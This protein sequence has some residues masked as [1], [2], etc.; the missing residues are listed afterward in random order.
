MGGCAGGEVG[1][2]WYRVRD[3]KLS[4][5]TTMGQGEAPQVGEGQKLYLKRRI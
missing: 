1:R 2:G 4:I 3:N 5:W